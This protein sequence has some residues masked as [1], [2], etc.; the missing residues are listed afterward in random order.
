M[1]K[2]ISVFLLLS[3]IL[4]TFVVTSEYSGIKFA[5]D[6]DIFKVIERMNLN[7]FAQNK[8]LIAADG[9]QID[10][11][12]FP[13]YHMK[14]ANLLINNVNN[15]KNVVVNTRSDSGSD[16][17]FL[18]IKITS[19][20]I[21]LITD[22]DIEVISI[23]NDSGRKTPIKVV[24]DSIDGEFYF[25]NGNVHFTKLQVQIGDIDIKFNSFWYKTIYYIGKSLIIKGINNKVSSLHDAL[26]KAL[27]QFI[28]SQFLIDVG[29]GIGFNATNVDRPE[30]Q[31]FERTTSY[32]SSKLE[33]VEVAS[34]N[35]LENSESVS[36]GFAGDDL[37]NTILKFGVH[38]SLYP[39]LSPDLRPEIQ[40]AGQMAYPEYLFNN[41]ISILISDY[42]LNSLL[43]MVQQTGALKKVLTNSTNE[44]LPFNIDT[45]GISG[46]IWGIFSD[47]GQLES[48][49]S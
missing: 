34:L 5:I 31:L 9:V 49:Y 28:S 20:Q 30:L 11:S 2:T 44:I 47:L 41:E 1:N 19:M 15:P 4:L 43:F 46:L 37:Y 3:C 35:F 8:T 7:K 39:N 40:P 29:M 16:T 32:E 6:T 14:I 24:L 42:T 12:S 45:Q 48:T 10:S 23:F 27:N 38:G 33:K 36:S 17:K 21:D 22:F 26:E 18:E 13:S 25:N